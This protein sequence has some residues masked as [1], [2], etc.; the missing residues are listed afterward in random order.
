MM[1]N[2]KPRLKC[3][4]CWI[5]F[6]TE[7]SVKKHKTKKHEEDVTAKSMEDALS[8]D[9]HSQVRTPSDWRVIVVVSKY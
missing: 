3:D 6:E 2:K 4:D 9:G 1:R 7:G 8:L 5:K